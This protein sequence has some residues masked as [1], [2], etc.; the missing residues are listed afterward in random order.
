MD[1]RIIWMGNIEKVMDKESIKSIF[2]DISM[3]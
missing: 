1:S 3:L 2:N